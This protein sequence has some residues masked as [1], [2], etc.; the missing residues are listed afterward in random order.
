MPTTADY[1]PLL[2]AAVGIEVR[3]SYATGA[4]PST[5]ILL[6]EN[7]NGLLLESGSG[8]LELQ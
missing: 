4:A 8:D 1:D 7:G 5:D 3:Q 2:G 6:L